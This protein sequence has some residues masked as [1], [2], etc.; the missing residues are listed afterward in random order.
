MPSENGEIVTLPGK[1]SIGSPISSRTRVTDMTTAFVWPVATRNSRTIPRPRMGMVGYE[2]KT[3]TWNQTY[4]RPDPPDA[5]TLVDDAQAAPSA[6]DVCDEG[7]GP[8]TGDKGET[9]TVAATTEITTDPT[10]IVIAPDA[11]DRPTHDRE[12]GNLLVRICVRAMDGDLDGPWVIS[13][14]QTVRERD[15]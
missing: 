12:E 15:E 11:F 7:D 2:A 6:D 10:G 9:W 1:P 13:G 14:T 8:V 5:D 3:V 4:D